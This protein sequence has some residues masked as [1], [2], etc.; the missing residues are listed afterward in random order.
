MRELQT[1]QEKE[2]TRQTKQQRQKMHIKEKTKHMEENNNVVTRAP[3]T[4]NSSNARKVGLQLKILQRV[5]FGG[6]GKES[7]SSI[8]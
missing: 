8:L 2:E 1:Q 3:L 5:W 7:T 6:E 4:Y